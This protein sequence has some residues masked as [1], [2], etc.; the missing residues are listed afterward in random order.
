MEVEDLKRV[1]S[2]VLRKKKKNQRGGINGN[3]KWLVEGE[4]VLLICNLQ[5]ISILDQIMTEP[6][7]ATSSS[8]P[9][10]LGVMDSLSSECTPLKH[11]YDNCF[12]LWLQDYLSVSPSNHPS[13]S[14]SPSAKEENK[15]SSWSTSS[16]DRKDK[17]DEAGQRR[18]R[19][20]ILKETLEKDCGELFREYQKCVKVSESDTRL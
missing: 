3:L 19:N 17:G 9:A 4:E 20:L 14:S 16:R 1:T 8:G 10:G 13:N 6:T 7:S 2:F 12:N 18:Q 5:L 11:K 15:W